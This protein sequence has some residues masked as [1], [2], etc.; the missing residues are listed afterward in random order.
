M[1]LQPHRKYIE[2]IGNRPDLSRL[3]SNF[4]RAPNR[5]FVVD[6]QTLLEADQLQ[7]DACSHDAADQLLGLLKDVMRMSNSPSDSV[8]A[9]AI[10]ELNEGGGKTLSER[11]IVR[12][13]SGAY[14][15]CDPTILSDQLEEPLPRPLAARIK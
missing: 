5:V 2:L 8:K 12:A 14:L 11:L 9:G 1:A 10:V 15:T 13:S 6:S 3:R 7:G 4:D